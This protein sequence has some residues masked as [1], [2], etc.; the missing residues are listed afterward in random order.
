MQIRTND[1][2]LLHNQRTGQYQ[3]GMLGCIR[4]KG[5]HHDFKINFAKSL[6]HELR[7]RCL[8]DDIGAVD[9]DH[10]DRRILGRQ[11]LPAN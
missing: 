4:H 11:N 10:L 5:I 7:I 9:P 2:L 8:V 6:Y 3:I 1:V